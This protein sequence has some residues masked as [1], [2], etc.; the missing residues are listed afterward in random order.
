MKISTFNAKERKKQIIQKWRLIWNT[1]DSKNSESNF[2]PTA[3][4]K[5]QGRSSRAERKF[6]KLGNWHI[7]VVVTADDALRTNNRE[8]KFRKRGKLDNYVNLGN[9]PCFVASRHAAVIN[10]NSSGGCSLLI[11][12]VACHIIPIFRDK[13]ASNIKRFNETFL[14]RS[15]EFHHFA[16]RIFESNIINKSL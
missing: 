4:L 9:Y 7:I 13:L 11:L 15:R 3:S 6:D 5:S 10:Q 16:G 1:H 2:I 14:P 12:S 8:D